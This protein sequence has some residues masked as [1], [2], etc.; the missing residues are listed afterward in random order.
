VCGQ[1]LCHTVT[2]SVCGLFLV[3]CTSLTRLRSRGRRAT[4]EHQPSRGIHFQTLSSCMAM[5]LHME[6]HT[7]IRVL[8]C[9]MWLE[10]SYRLDSAKALGASHLGRCYPGV[11]LCPLSRAY[12]E[13]VE[14]IVGTNRLYCAQVPGPIR[15]RIHP[16]FSRE[17]GGCAAGSDEL[18]AF[19]LHL[20][21]ADDQHQ[22]RTCFA[23]TGLVY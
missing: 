8:S 4:G 12:A 15:T 17:M 19:E 13:L 22:R 23:A 18:Q 9:L 16:V 11:V 1:V 7:T 2:Q 5:V 21:A 10:F 3:H 20:K 14:R 6:Y